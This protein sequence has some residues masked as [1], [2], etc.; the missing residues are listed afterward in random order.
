MS[1]LPNQQM[2]LRRRQGVKAEW[3]CRTGLTHRR[4]MTKVRAQS[5]FHDQPFSRILGEISVARGEWLKF[6]SENRCSVNI[7]E[8]DRHYRR[9][10]VNIHLSEELQPGVG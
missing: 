1:L 2:V 9:A 6:L 10:A 8:T 3:R 7:L 5:D 4:R